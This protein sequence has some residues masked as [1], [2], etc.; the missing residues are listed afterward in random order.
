MFAKHIK[1]LD[2]QMFDP[3]I[4]VSLTEE[5]YLEE[6][7]ATLK[8]PFLIAKPEFIFIEEENISHHIKGLYQNLILTDD[9]IRIK[10]KPLMKQVEERLVSE[11]LERYL[12]RDI[13]VRNL[14]FKLNIDFGYKHDNTMDLIQSI[15]LQES[16]RENYKEGVFW[17]EAV[18]KL[19][20]DNELNVGE[21][22]AIVR[23]PSNAQKI[24]FSELIRQFDSID[25]V[26]VVNYNT[27]E[28]ERFIHVLK[29]PRGLERAL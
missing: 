24:G 19:Q 1:D 9:E 5:T 20:S 23:P 29:N 15:S 12:E 4:N 8:M 17:K 11:G 22:T 2:S 26:T 7:Q 21:F 13:K 27:P 18:L 28:F 25:H 16:P 3:L 6:L 14:P 10:R